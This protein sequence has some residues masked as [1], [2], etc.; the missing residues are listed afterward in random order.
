MRRPRQNSETLD[1]LLMSML[2]RTNLSGYD[3]ARLLKDPIPL[4]W[5][6]KHSQ[7]YPAL[8]NLE[9]R[10]EIDGE[11]VD[12][13]GRPAKKTYSL[14][15]LGRTRLREWL[16]QPR[17]TLSQEEAIL[18]A[19]NFK[20]VGTE[21]AVEAFRTYRKQ[22]EQEI[23]LLEERWAHLA[24]ILQSGD[25]TAGPRAT[26][27]FALSTRRARIMWCDQVIARIVADPNLAQTIDN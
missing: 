27:E 20:L 6:V 9:A 21:A 11:W 24:D 12:Q 13:K 3:I 23:G 22:A 19:Y 4:I 2:N 18:L 7:I 10:G 8:A 25:G 16:V 14:A 1:M 5:P 26:F 15:T 17:Q